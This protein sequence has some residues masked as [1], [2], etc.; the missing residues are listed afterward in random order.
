MPKNKKLLS[1]IVLLIAIGVFFSLNPGSTRARVEKI[2]EVNLVASY[3][4]EALHTQIKMLQERIFILQREIKNLKKT[5]MPVMSSPAIPPSVGILPEAIKLTPSNDRWCHNFVQMLKYGSAGPEV[6]ALQQALLKEGFYKKVPSGK[7]DE[8]TAS[9]VVGFQEK[10]ASEILHPWGLE[11]G[12]GYVGRTTIKKL[13]DLFGC[14]IIAPQNKSVKI[15][16]PRGGERWILEDTYLIEWKYAGFGASD[17]IIIYADRGVRPVPIVLE[18][19]KI[20]KRGDLNSLEKVSDIKRVFSKYSGTKI[21]KAGTVQEVSNPYSWTIPLSFQPGNYKI[22]VIMV[23]LDDFD[24]AQD[25]SKGWVKIVQRKEKKKIVLSSPNGGEQF[26]FGST[27][28]IKWKC[29][30][31]ISTGTVRIMLED[32]ARQNED[33]TTPFTLDLADVFCKNQEY[34]WE[35]NFGLESHSYKVK[36]YLIDDP[37]LSDESDNYFSIIKEFIPG[38]DSCEYNGGW[39]EPES[40]AKY[41]GWP[42]GNEGY[43]RDCCCCY[44]KSHIHDLREKFEDKKV[45]IKYRPGL[46]QGCSDTMKV[47]SSVDGENWRRVLSIP[48]TQETWSPK[49]TYENTVDILGPFRYIK[50]S[51]PHCYNDYSSV[52][53]IG[54]AEEAE[55]RLISHWKF[56]EGSGDLVYDSVGENHGRIYSAEWTDGVLGKALEFKHKD[57]VWS[58]PHFFDDDISTAF[59]ISSWIYWYGKHPDT[60]SQNSYIFDGRSGTQSWAKGFI[61]F[62]NKEGKLTLLLGDANPQKVESISSIPIKKWTHVAGVYD[63]KTATLALYINGGRDNIA[64]TSLLYRNSD[65]IAGIGNNHWAPGDAQWAPFNGKIDEIRLYN[66]ALNS[67]EVK[68]IYK[69]ISS[70][71]SLEGLKAE[72]FS[73]KEV[74]GEASKLTEIEFKNIENWLASISEAVSRLIDQVRRFLAR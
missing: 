18:V 50:I 33:K 11:H 26:E 30:I 54:D 66:K 34:Y 21:I 43:K 39:S 3:D 56:D 69:D 22:G 60:Y 73:E 4:I 40:A 51:I 59:T 6:V 27:I 16:S 49:T 52:K 1:F 55:G 72:S 2:S 46:H 67:S 62:V 48:V 20:R 65:S 13:S 36:I 70:E 53:I 28:P 17:L 12:T 32:F 29:D 23:S 31:S 47:Y 61:F 19:E 5:E 44:L 9:A 15:I 25:E 10:Y 68:E 58:I 41:C 8:Y 63:Y 7:F 74:S 38:Y 14:G 24:F 45:L 71:L 42:P 37:S 64:T 35:E 57:L